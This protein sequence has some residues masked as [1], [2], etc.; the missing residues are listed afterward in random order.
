M[1]SANDGF[2]TPAIKLLT[3]LLNYGCENCDVT[4]LEGILKEEW[5]R[6]LFETAVQLYQDNIFAYYYDIP[7]EETLKRHSTKV[8]FEFGKF[9]EK[10]MKK[11]WNEKDYIGFIPEKNISSDFSLDEAAAMIFN[12]VN[13]LN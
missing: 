1:L 11:W 10:E 9:G 4:I 2:D 8:Y 7:F 6:P 3:T 5:Y 13:I 12:D